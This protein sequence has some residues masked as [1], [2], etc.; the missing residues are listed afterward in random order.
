[1]GPFPITYSKG[2]K[3][4]GTVAFSASFYSDSMSVSNNSAYAVQVV[5]TDAATLDV[6]VELQASID[7]ANWVDVE[8]T[9]D[10]T[11]TADGNVLFDVVDAAYPQF[12]LKLTF[13]T[14]SCKIAAQYYAKRG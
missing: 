1:M 9:L 7:G 6:D 4:D 11:V 5:V 8:D 14:G 12:R 13:T 2:E 10:T 3:F